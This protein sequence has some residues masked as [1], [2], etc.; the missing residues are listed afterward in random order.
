[1]GDFR[2][3]MITRDDGSR[4]GAHSITINGLNTWKSWHM[5]PKSRP[6]VVAPKVKTEYVDVPGAD[7]ALDY[8]E[9][10]TGRPRYANR[11]GQWDFI[12]D[13]GL[14]YV[15]WCKLYSDILKKLHGK[16]FDTI[17]LED[18]PEYK[19]QGRLSVTGQ[20]GNKD[21]SSVTI[22]YNLDPYKR[23]IDSTANKNWLWKELFSN[24]IF[25]GNFSVNGFKARNLINDDVEPVTVNVEVS[26][27]MDAIPYDGTEAAQFTMLS[28]SFDQHIDNY[29][30]RIH[31]DTGPNSIELQP[32]NNYFFF[33]GNGLVKVEQER[34]KLL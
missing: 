13:N 4:V 34:G 30:N 1:M 31:L 19:W 32:G 16:Y 9:V 11:T 23:P 26:Y 24:T 8:T 22:Q 27:Q 10:L 6:F 28:G 5:A 25:Y 15:E 20:F 33:V 14:D 3:S 12:V 18:E 21:Y 29:S 2:Y 7:G 17:V